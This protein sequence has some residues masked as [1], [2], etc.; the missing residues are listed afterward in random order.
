MGKASNFKKLRKFSNQLPDIAVPNKEIHIVKGSQL[1][2]EYGTNITPLGTTIE[3]DT[4]YNVPMPIIM[5]INHDRRMKKAYNKYGINGA[6]AYIE[7]I[8]NH[9]KDANT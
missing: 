7:V 6:L 3:P 9:I 4:V 1:I 2:E 8:K 5:Q